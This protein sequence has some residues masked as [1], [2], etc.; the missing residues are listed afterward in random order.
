MKIRPQRKTEP[1]RLSKLLGNDKNRYNLTKLGYFDSQ[2]D[3]S[4]FKKTII[5]INKKNMNLRC[6]FICCM[7]QKSCSSQGWLNN[8]N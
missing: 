8:L 2:L 1:L 7:Y 5:S 3:K 6:S 4:Y